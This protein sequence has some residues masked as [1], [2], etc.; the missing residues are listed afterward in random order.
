MTEEKIVTKIQKLLAKA[1][2]TNSVHEAEAL[3][4]K[5]QALMVQYAID[6]A[7]LVASGK[8]SRETPVAVDAT[9]SDPYFMAKARLLARVAKY[10][11][12]ESIIIST[13][14]R[15][16]TVVGMPSDVEFV[17]ILF[18]SL[19][20]QLAAALARVVPTGD[21]RAYRKGVVNGYVEEVNK[22]LYAND[23][24][25]QRAKEEVNA[26][27]SATGTALV[28]RDNSTDVA[29]AVKQLFPSITYTVSRA[30]RGSSAGL[31]AGQS[32]GA[33]ADVSGGRGRVGGT[34]ATLGR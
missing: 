1:E 27:G 34:R 8:R 15:R 14:A 4:E 31:S 10:N 26:D 19:L 16:C 29:A 33:R 23:Q 6:E 24:V 2:S 20:I 3:F 18:S 25:R 17:Q 13:K 7:R 30:S 22:R 21:P 32:A 9:I 12:C 11:G 28:L 5:A